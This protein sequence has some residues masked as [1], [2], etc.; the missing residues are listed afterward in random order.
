MSAGVGMTV[1]WLA[2]L[3]RFTRGVNRAFLALSGALAVTVMVI[4][5]Q[6]V[7]RRYVFND[8]SVWALD[9]ASFLLVYLFFLA[10]A[11]ALQSGSHVTVDLFNELLPVGLQRRLLLLGHVL[12]V[13]FGCVFFWQLF[14]AAREAFA[15][16][17]L[18]PTATPMRVK[19]VWVIGPIGC[20]QFVLT[21][22]VLLATSVAEGRARRAS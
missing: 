17:E 6:D 22:I 11:P 5:L 21:A 15:D 19:Y 3:A 13:A 9:V 2:G 4:V 20:A 16:N 1:G 10:L 18:F 7:I 12:L 14:V 8:P